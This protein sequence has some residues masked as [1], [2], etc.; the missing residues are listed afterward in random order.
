VIESWVDV[1]ADVA[2]INRGEAIQRADL[3]VANDRAYTLEPGGRLVPISGP[4]IH[5]LSR[6]AFHALG[7][8]N[9]FGLTERAESILDRMQT[10]ASEREVARR[11]WRLEHKRSG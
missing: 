2:T 3:L 7:V 9:T 4:G 1:G 10:V 5:V 6:A 11:M 8:Y